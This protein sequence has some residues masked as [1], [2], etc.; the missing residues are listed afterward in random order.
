M[1][2]QQQARSRSP[3]WA[4]AGQTWVDN[5]GASAT[6]IGVYFVAQELHGFS[7]GQNFVLGLLQGI[8]YITGALSA[9]PVTRRLAGPGR[10]ISTRAFLA[11]LHVALFACTQLPLW[12]SSPTAIWIMVGLFSTLSGVL[13]PLVESFHSAGR[14]GADLRRGSSIFN[15]SWASCQVVTFWALAPFMA[16]NPSLAIPAL[17]LSNLVAMLFL[18]WFSREPA[19]HAHDPSHTPSSDHRQG[20]RR[21]LEGHR[22]LLILSYVVYSALTPMLPILIE[23]LSVRDGWAT[24]LTS[25]W[26]FT[27]VLA[28]WIMGL[29]SGWQGRAVTLVW[30]GVLLTAGFLVCALAPSAA[31][32]AVGLAVF[33]TGMGAIYSTAFYYAMEVG[34]SGVDAG[35]KHEALIGLGYLGGPALGVGAGLIVGSTSRPGTDALAVALGVTVLAAATA[36]LIALRVRTVRPGT[37]AR[38]T[39]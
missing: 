4:T 34:A 32:L 2:E 18:P 27:R 35:G 13:W 3:S 14:T 30:P 10:A 28:F 31:V 8:T 12:W 37:P 36:A 17:G 20:L 16:L 38:S 19:P 21:L 29:W 24:V 7:T 23:R 33:G 11:W 6:L 39:H 5:I 22:F 25:V 1:H 9:G 15:L 26:M